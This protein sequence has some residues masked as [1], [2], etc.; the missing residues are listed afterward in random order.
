MLGLRGWR[1]GAGA[2]VAAAVAMGGAVGGACSGDAVSGVEDTGLAPTD[3]VF[4]D[5]ADDVLVP[6]DSAT[7]GATADSADP[8]ATADSADAARVETDPCGALPYDFRCPCDINNDCLSG[9][10]LPVDDPRP[11][12]AA[13]RT[14]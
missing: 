14:A 10:C 6:P 5:G 13:P 3:V 9:W 7:T 8:D 4:A 2:M 12:R 1:V 11:R